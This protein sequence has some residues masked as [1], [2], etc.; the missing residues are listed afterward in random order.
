MAEN[1]LAFGEI[2]GHLPLVLL[3]P[4]HPRVAQERANVG[5][6]HSGAPQQRDERCL[7]QL[8]RPVVAIARVRIDPRGG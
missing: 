4:L 1:P 7:S 5:N 6:W 2:V 3:E 8:V